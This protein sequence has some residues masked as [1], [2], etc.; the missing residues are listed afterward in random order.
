MW[1]H[2]DGNS[3]IS[4][5]GTLTSNTRFTHLLVLSFPPQT[6]ILKPSLLQYKTCGTLIGNHT[7]F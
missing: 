6:K 3:L 2:Y 1:F 7:L 4:K 5:L